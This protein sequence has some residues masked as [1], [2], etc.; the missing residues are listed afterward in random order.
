VES[1]TDNI[2]LGLIYCFVGEVMVDGV[3]CP[4]CDSTFPDKAALSKHIDQVHIGKGLLEGDRR[5]W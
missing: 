3:R 1:L 2:Y 5:K 4:Y